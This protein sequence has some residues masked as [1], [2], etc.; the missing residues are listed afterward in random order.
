MDLASNVITTSSALVVY[1]T[2]HKS[3]KSL[4][5]TLRK[6]T[7]DTDRAPPE[8]GIFIVTFGAWA[9]QGL[10]VV[11][12]LARCYTESAGDSAAADCLRGGTTPCAHNPQLSPT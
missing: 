11:S 6:L 2:M 4:G 9:M 8:R 10:T 12:K 1:V 7:E 5:S 3:A